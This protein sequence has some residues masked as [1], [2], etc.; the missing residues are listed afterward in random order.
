MIAGLEA[1]EER[2]LILSVGTHNADR[3][4]TPA[5]VGELTARALG[6][7]ESVATLA[8]KL[9]LKDRSM[10]SRFRKINSLPWDVLEL[11]AWG[12]PRDGLSLSAAAEIV[13]APPSLRRELARRSIEERLSKE[14]VR[15]VVQRVRSGDEL[16]N[17]VQNILEWQPRVVKRHVYLGTLEPRVRH[18]LASKSAS[19]LAAV[20]EA[21]AR[22]L[23]EDETLSLGR[24]TFT[25]GRDG[26]PSRHQGDD[27]GINQALAD[28]LGV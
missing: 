19:E 1:A 16:E 11:V 27:A 13:S 22:G 7:G 24:S 17:A 18:A 23:P 8:S 25:L 26:T 2:D 5:E 3:R 28:V 15:A 14:A 12:R 10:I 20:A 6:S 21:A 9:G 4:L